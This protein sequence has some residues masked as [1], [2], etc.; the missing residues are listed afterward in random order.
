M[1]GIHGPRL[2]Q[3]YLLHQSG[4]YFYVYIVPR[5][6]W[7]ALRLCIFVIPCVILWEGH[8]LVSDH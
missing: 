5:L 2:V 1:Y 7:F 3:I 6:A 4:H 8:P